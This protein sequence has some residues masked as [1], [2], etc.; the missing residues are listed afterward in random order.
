MKMNEKKAGDRSGHAEYYLL[1]SNQC[2]KT[3]EVM[4]CLNRI[5][6]VPKIVTMD[7]TRTEVIFGAI[8]YFERHRERER[9]R[10]REGERRE[11]LLQLYFDKKRRS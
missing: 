6:N 5:F 4:R 8:K 11:V 10:E 3:I 2:I 7:R 1:D 9:E